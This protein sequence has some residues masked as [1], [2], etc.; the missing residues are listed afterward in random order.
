[1]CTTAG[2]TYTAAQIP[3]YACAAKE[4]PFPAGVTEDRGKP[5]VL[6]VH[7]NSDTPGEF[8]KF[9]ADSAMPMLSERLTAA[10][11]RTLAVDYRID[12]NDDPQSNNDTENAAR[13]VDHAW[14]T[15]IVEHFIA[16]MM[17]ANPDRK[18]TI[19]GFS[20]G[21]TVVRDALRRLHN[22]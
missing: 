18:I 8:E 22:R 17:S 13:N 2:L 20:L 7:G 10:G 1:G 15:P 14:A 5:I 19:I 4:Y 16:S 12:K 11:F 3:G 6:L 9:P 21:T